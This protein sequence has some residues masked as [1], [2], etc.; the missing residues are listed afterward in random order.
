MAGSS[1]DI[2]AL[3]LILPHF[4]FLYALSYLGGVSSGN[5]VMGALLGLGTAAVIV[6]NTVSAWTA[7]AVYQPQG[8]DV[9]QFFFFR[10]RTLD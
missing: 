7:W 10:W 2:H 8:Y 4:N 9:Y 1:D 5:A 3:S 6:L